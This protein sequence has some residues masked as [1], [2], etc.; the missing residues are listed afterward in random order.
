MTTLSLNLI[1]G[2][3]LLW[4]QS[5]FCRPAQA[6]LS[7]IYLAALLLTSKLGA[8]FPSTVLFP[9]WSMQWWL[10]LHSGHPVPSGSREMSSGSNVVC[11]HCEAPGARCS[12]NTRNLNILTCGGGWCFDTSSSH[13][14]LTGLFQKNTRQSA[15][16]FILLCKPQWEA[17]PVLQT[18]CHKS[19]DYLHLLLNSSFYNWK[20][21]PTASL[22]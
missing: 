12:I 7:F 18:G 9:H 16:E 8:G 19:N 22:H 21:A 1:L 15:A 10:D 2:S 14:T 4:R 17:A 13:C 3:V 6:F 5:P 20:Y 11:R